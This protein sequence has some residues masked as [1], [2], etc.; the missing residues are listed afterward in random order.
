VTRTR[1]LRSG[2]LNDRKSTAL[3]GTREKRAKKPAGV[4]PR[5][6]KNCVIIATGRGYLNANGEPRSKLPQPGRNFRLQAEP[7]ATEK[8]T[9]GPLSPYCEKPGRSS[10]C[11]LRLNCPRAIPQKNAPKVATLLAAYP[12]RPGQDGCLARDRREGSPRKDL[13]EG[14]MNAAPHHKGNCRGRE[15]RSNYCIIRRKEKTKLITGGTTKTG[16]GATEPVH[17]RQGEKKFI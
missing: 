17:R 1:C 10:I 3:V 5:R 13:Q 11:E 2:S 15:E 9:Q 7:T 14:R 8:K 16:L 12:R 6:R 4:H